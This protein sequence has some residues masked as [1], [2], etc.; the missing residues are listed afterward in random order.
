MT[1]NNFKKKVTE[2]EK[3]GST[4]DV[5]KYVVNITLSTLGIGAICGLLVINVLGRVSFLL[6]VLILCGLLFLTM[7]DL[8]A[9]SQEAFNKAL[10]FSKLWW[11]FYILLAGVVFALVYFNFM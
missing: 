1:F 6:A 5:T 10:K 11:L 4:K 8:A 9:T 7:F 2:E 3:W